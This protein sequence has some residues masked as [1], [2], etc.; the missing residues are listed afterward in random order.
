MKITNR[1]PKEF[2]IAAGAGQTGFGPGNDP[3]ETGSYDQALVDAGIENFNIVKY[4]SVIPPEA[5]EISMEDAV[6]RGLTHHGM[7]L[8]CIM[9]RQDGIQ[10]E[11]VCAGVGRASVWDDNGELIGGFATEYEGHGSTTF[12]ARELKTALHGIFERRN[13]ED[14]GYSMGDMH[15]VTKDL[16]IDESFGTV[17]VAVGFMTFTLI[18][19]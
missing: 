17:L 1:I 14:K 11:H 8:E 12:A 9:A 2:V 3:F 7:V 4:T 6:S 5:Y 16:V 15:F 19:L 18:V 10:G 13:Y